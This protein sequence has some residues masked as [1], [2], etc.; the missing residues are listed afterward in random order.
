MRRFASFLAI[1]LALIGAG[2]A[3]A[4][5]PAPVITTQPTNQTTAVGKTATFKV[6]ATGTGTLSY[7]WWKDNSPVSK[8]TSASYTTAPATT[9]DINNPHS[10]WVV[11]TNTVGG[12]GNS[13]QSNIVTMQV[14]QPPTI[15]QQPYSVTVT[16]PAIAS[17]ETD[18]NPY[19]QLS[20]QWYKNGAK[21]AGATSNIYTLDETSVADNGVKFTCVATN[22]AGSVT[23]QAATLTVKASATGTYPIVGNWAGTA[24]IVSASD[25]S[26]SK[27]NVTAS[28]NQNSYSLIGTIAFTDD[29]GTT[30]YGAGIAALNS[31]NLFTSFATDDNTSASIA[32]AFSSNQLTF[33]G[34]A[35]NADGSNGTGTFTISSDKKTLT[36]NAT[37]SIGDSFTFTLKRK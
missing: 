2:L 34:S 7:Q 18:A 12:V 27:S 3:L 1:P 29:D 37:D 6:V 15:Y 30:N 13:I 11:V 16:E 36:G 32:A 9:N 24:T 31:V 4:A 21:I 8:A 5:T 28:F 25:K 35:A 17:F 14:V 33:T 20:Y 23:S 19:G 22:P 26:T 10:F